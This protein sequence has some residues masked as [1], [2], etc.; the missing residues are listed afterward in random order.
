MF[1]SILYWHC[2]IKCIFP[3]W[4]QDMCKLLNSVQNQRHQGSKRSIMKQLYTCSVEVAVNTVNPS[5][6]D[7]RWREKINLNFYFH[8]SLWCLK[9]F[10]E[11]LKGLHKTFW[12]TT[13]EYEN[14]NL[15]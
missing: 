7:P 15:S 14:K 10:Y 11:G 3:Y 5:H 4:F 13:K 1:T 12:G 2:L 6:R 8:T 9:R